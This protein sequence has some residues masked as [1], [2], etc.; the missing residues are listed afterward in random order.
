[1]LIVCASAM[2]R[3]DCTITNKCILPLNSASPLT[4]SNTSVPES[5]PSV[6][7][8]GSPTTIGNGSSHRTNSNLGG[9][10]SVVKFDQLN[11]LDFSLLDKEEEEDLYGPPVGKGGD[12]A[13]DEDQDSD[14]DSVEE[15]PAKPKKKSSSQ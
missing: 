5:A 4:E 3:R 11:V 8:S 1:M 14:I 13:T 6:A 15:S 9:V 12:T 7:T 10:P 2:P